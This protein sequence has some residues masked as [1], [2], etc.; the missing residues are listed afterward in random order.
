MAVA[1]T[2]AARWAASWAEVARFNPNHAPAGSAAGGQF[3]AG[4]SGAAP[5]N[6][7]PVGSGAKGA[8]VS[9]LQKRL[10]ALGMKP[11]LKVDGIFGPKTLAAVKAFQV[12]H[13]LKVDGLVGPKTTSALRAKAPA[14]KAPAHKAPAKH[15]APAKAPAKKAPAKPATAKPAAKPAT[16][17]TAS[18]EGTAVRSAAEAGRR[19]AGAGQCPARRTEGASVMADTDPKATERLH[20]YWVHG[21]GAAKI[22]WGEPDDFRR[23]VDHLGKYIKDPQGYC[24]LAHKAATGMYPAQ[25]A[26]MEKKATGR[27]AVTTTTTQRAQLATSD[28]NDLDD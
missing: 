11:P 8:Q 22:R 16:A 28:I 9:D 12:S 18:R 26:A 3:A 13:G 19:V 7:A 10:N 25:H 24:N 14:K 5:T 6:A 2:W 20:E 4:S 23:C 17:K 21:E 15:P 27:S 1:D